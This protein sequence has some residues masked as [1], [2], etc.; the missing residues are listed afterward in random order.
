MKKFIIFLIVLFSISVL[1][2][3]SGFTFQSV[4]RDS[5][6]VPQTNVS[7]YL[8]F[9]I[10]EG[11]ETGN[12]VYQERQTPTT[13]DYGYISVSI[14][15]GQVVSG[16][17]STIDWSSG[18]MF[19]SIDCSD[20]EGGQFSEISTSLINSAPFVGPKGDKG[21]LGDQGPKGDPG[22]QGPKGNDGTGVKIIGSVPDAGSLP[23][24]YNGSIGDLYISQDTGTGYV[25]DGNNW[26]NVGQIKG[27]KGDSGQKGDKGDKG[28]QGAQ[29][30]QGDKGDKG[31]QGPRG[32]AGIYT[33]GSGISIS[34]NTI[35]ASDNSDTNEI[36]TL[37]FTGTSLTLSNGGGTIDLGSLSLSLPYYNE[38]NQEGALFHIHNGHDK[39][40]YGLAGTI[41]N[42]NAIPEGAGAG[43]I[44]IGYRGV[45]GIS[46]S[47]FGAGVVG[48]S[49]SDEGYGIHGRTDGDGI[50]GY[51]ETSTT[52]R[53]A[54]ATGEGNVGIG[55][56]T[57]HSKLEISDDTKTR[58]TLN[59]EESGG[60]SS[61]GFKQFQGVDS[62][63]GWLWE[64]DIS[65]LSNPKLSLFDYDY[66]IGTPNNENKKEVYKIER[67]LSMFGD[68]FY[69]HKFSGI[70]EING[71][72]DE[73]TSLS[74]IPEVVDSVQKRFEY[75]AY[76][77]TDEDRTVLSLDFLN[78]DTKA[79]AS[80]YTIPQNMYKAT[81]YS[82]GGQRHDFGDA[83]YIRENSY[84]SS[85]LNLLI[86]AVNAD[87]YIYHSASKIDD[88]IT[89][90][91]GETIIGTAG[92]AAS[93]NPLYTATSNPGV[94]PSGL[95]GSH[96][97]YGH[98]QTNG[99]SITP[100]PFSLT[101]EWD[102]KIY[103]NSPGTDNQSAIHIDADHTTIPAMEVHNIDGGAAIS[104]SGPIH[105]NLDGA[106]TKKHQFIMQQKPG[107]QAY[108]ML[109]QNGDSPYNNWEISVA[110]ANNG[111]MRLYF[112]GINRGV[113]NSTSGNYSSVSDERLKT[114]IA[115]L[116]SV[117]PSL[118]RLSPKIYNYR[119][120]LSQS[121][122]GFLAQDIQ[123]LF[124]ELV[125]E[126]Q[127][128]EGG[129]STL[130]VDYSQLTVLAIKAI[131]EQQAII[132]YCSDKISQ[133]QQ[134]N[135]EIKQETKALKHQ[136]EQLVKEFNNL[137][138]KQ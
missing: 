89:Y 105:I 102:S 112:N 18:L 31:D 55:I 98:I 107:G 47:D 33:A 135:S 7:V 26:T 15:Q 94:S 38:G 29:G 62:Y 43:V 66:N 14:G 128:R 61:L 70:V 87:H 76:H 36:Q 1:N 118:L 121:F 106:T 64:S 81:H 137:R 16:D 3:Q 28:D 119:S 6:G 130:M 20:N 30:L 90:D 48:E 8:Q 54:L 24:P 85:S 103:I 110:P 86:P 35:S 79:G 41:G 84:G 53:A 21:D 122:N 50:G 69:T 123:S 133:L 96:W 12:I 45:Y 97:F 23:I 88:N 13:D 113:F 75:Y 111:E 32:P 124:P 5:D 46:N 93:T 115:S 80:M 49:S 60:M 77:S 95:G 58:M 91:F 22:P 63:Q 19:L 39:K 82:G 65:D 117:L 4:I 44:G 71:G 83:I 67:G 25:W 134:E 101:H 114:N 127:S 57:P 108:G 56:K 104:T 17:Y 78:V 72:S 2:A 52:G 68:E 9:S 136:V 74:M 10:H 42:S 27:P 40:Q 51:F 99:F 138:K 131:Q 34:G 73:Y 92:G 11:S 132:D 37:Q 129:E 109:L 126:V 59:G 125:T 116:S 120:N 100:A